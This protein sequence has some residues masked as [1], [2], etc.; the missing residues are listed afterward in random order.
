MVS[1]STVTDHTGLVRMARLDMPE[2][3]DG[4]IGKIARVRD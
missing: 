1:R 2:A 3:L 4:L